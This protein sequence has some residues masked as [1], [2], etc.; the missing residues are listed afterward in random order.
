MPKLNWVLKA[1]NFL[2]LYEDGGIERLNYAKL[3]AEK[4][5]LITNQR[6]KPKSKFKLIKGETLAIDIYKLRKNLNSKS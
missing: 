4:Q 6:W 5:R 1:F 2:K 3:L